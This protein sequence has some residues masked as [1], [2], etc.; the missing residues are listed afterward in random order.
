[1]WLP[2]EAAGAAGMGASWELS[3][4][5]KPSA[6]GQTVCPRAKGAWLSLGCPAGDNQDCMSVPRACVFLGRRWRMELPCCCLHGPPPAPQA[7][8]FILT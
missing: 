7:S 2:G 1:M 4:D 8:E 3:E 5:L 6:L